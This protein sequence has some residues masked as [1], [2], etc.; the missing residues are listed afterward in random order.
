MEYLYPNI[1]ILVF[2][3]PPITG[4]CKTRL[5]PLLGERGAAQLQEKLIHKIISDL[6]DFKLCPFELWQSEQSNYFAQRKLFENIKLQIQEGNNL[7]ERMCNALHSSLKTSDGVIVI[8]SDCV[9]YSRAYLVSAIESLMY[10]DVVV[11][12]AHDGGYV[13]IGLSK[14]RP[15]IFQG[16]KWGS[17]DV[18]EMTYRKLAKYNIAFDTLE[19]LHDVDQPDD[20]LHLLKIEPGWL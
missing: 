4:K 8:G 20:L 10:H 15:Q 5:I 13:L 19:T 3:N 14:I 16:I 12:P 17:A 9:E 1:K 6:A 18:L 2:T 11:G 7:G